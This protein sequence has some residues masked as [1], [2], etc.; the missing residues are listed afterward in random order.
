MRTGS[1]MILCALQVFVNTGGAKPPPRLEMRFDMGLSTH[2]ANQM[3]LA[4]ESGSR[5]I[6]VN[7]TPTRSKLLKEDYE[8]HNSGSYQRCVR[9]GELNGTPMS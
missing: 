3:I 6:F 2:P 1:A 5:L 9:L 7:W 8:P 4:F